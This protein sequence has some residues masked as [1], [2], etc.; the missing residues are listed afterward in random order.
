MHARVGAA[1]DGRPH[2][3]VGVADVPESVASTFPL[4]DDLIVQ[5]SSEEG[6]VSG[7]SGVS[8]LS[9]ADLIDLY[10]N[11]LPDAGYEVERLQ[12]VA[13]VFAVLDDPAKLGAIE[14]A[15]ELESTRLKRR[16]IGEILAFL[17]ALTDPAALDFRADVPLSVP[18]GLPLGD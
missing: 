5:I 14:A 8:Q 11:G 18:S 4:P 9:F 16:Q 1:P 12:F 15:N 3:P 13:D 2:V 7:F 6:D 17:R 10:E